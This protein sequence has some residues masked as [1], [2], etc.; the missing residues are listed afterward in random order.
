MKNK[1][2]TLMVTYYSYNLFQKIAFH[3][4]LT[5]LTKAIYMQGN[6]F[7]GVYSVHMQIITKFCKLIVK[8]LLLGIYSTM[9]Y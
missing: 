9:K 3:A 5:F 4:P 1:N 6:N 2:E 8:P 7:I